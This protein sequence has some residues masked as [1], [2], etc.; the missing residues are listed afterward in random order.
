[1]EWQVTGRVEEILVRVRDS[2]ADPAKERWSDARLL[3]LVDEAQKT[4]VKKARLLRGSASIAIFADQNIYNLPDEAYLLTRVVNSDGKELTVY[5]HDQMDDDHPISTVFGNS[6]N[7]YI[8]ESY[9]KPV[10][11]WEND[12]G[13]T[14]DKIIFDKLEPKQLK[15]YPIPLEGDK[16]SDTF[17]SS[18]YGVVTAIDSD[19]ISQDFGAL[20]DVTESATLSV[21]FNSVFGVVTAMAEVIASL[22]V[23]YYRFPASIVNSTDLLEVDT[24]YDKAIKHYVIGVSLRD[25]HD[26]QNRKVGNEELGFYVDELGDAKTESSID[27][28]SK[29]AQQTTYNGGIQ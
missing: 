24:M 18:D 1:M 22:K 25:D 3:R 6:G 4:I 17:T 16:G 7:R 14:I 12:T 20:T 5:S 23:Y 19:L 2:L 26:A 15:V 28:M 10:R 8:N 11:A 9:A 29:R 27:H 21:S 13:N